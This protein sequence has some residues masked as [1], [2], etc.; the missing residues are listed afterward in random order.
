MTA[1]AEPARAIGHQRRSPN[2]Q[3]VGP[4]L[5]PAREVP[6]AAA[7]AAR[8]R[9]VRQPAATALPAAERA[10]DGAIEGAD[11]GD[12]SRPRRRGAGRGLVVGVARWSSG[13]RWWW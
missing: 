12:V 3:Q 10:D 2:A 7:L 5:L 6:H 13:C 1:A 11:V 9:L 8:V 4:W